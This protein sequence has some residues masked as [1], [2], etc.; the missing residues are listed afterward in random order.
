MKKIILGF[1]AL[2]AMAMPMAAM[3]AMSA[4][5]LHEKYGGIVIDETVLVESDGGTVF[6]PVTLTEK[7]VGI[8]PV[9]LA[10][11]IDTIIAPVVAV[12]DVMEA[13]K[14]GG[15]GYPDGWSKKNLI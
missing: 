5:P 8:G 11:P 2:M 6:A 15:A 1:A 9:K 3:A 10:L 12:S 7:D 13:A 14:G 4:E